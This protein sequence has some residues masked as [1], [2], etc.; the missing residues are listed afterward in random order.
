MTRIGPT[1]RFTQAMF[2]AAVVTA[3]ICLAMAAIVHTNT[4]FA[5][6]DIA[7]ETNVCHCPVP[8]AVPDLR[9][10]TIRRALLPGGEIPSMRAWLA[11][12]AAWEAHPARALLPGLRPP[13]PPPRLPPTTEL[14]LPPLPDAGSG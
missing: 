2:A 10:A 5:T 12:T 8:G 11:R 6:R 1:A 7:A 9:V 4:V 3:V 13:L 14:R